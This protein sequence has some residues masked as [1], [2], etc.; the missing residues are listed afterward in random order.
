MSEQ[1]RLESLPRA[2]LTG[3]LLWLVLVWVPWKAILHQ[4]KTFDPKIDLTEEHDPEQAE[5][6]LKAAHRAIEHTDDK[7]KQLLTLSSA[8][9]T[10]LV[11]FGRGVEPSWLVVFAVIALLFAVLLSVF[12]LG[13]RI[14][15]IPDPEGKKADPKASQWARDV[16]K[17]SVFSRR[18][19]LFLV[20][21][22]AGAR[23]WLIVALILLALILV[24]RDPSPNPIA[25]ELTAF[26]KSVEAESGRLQNRLEALNEDLRAALD[27]LNED[28]EAIE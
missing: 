13:V 5:F 12:L 18:R 4:T 9:A 3:C 21:L 20:D 28:P 22:Y 19:H 23:R 6:L 10:L 2:V 8:L 11:V 27:K 24:Y 15:M 1:S 17:S 7:A 26:R 25:G 14:E 16:L